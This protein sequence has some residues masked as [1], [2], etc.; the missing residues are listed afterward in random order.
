MQ[1]ATRM[2]AIQWV[3]ANPYEAVFN[4]QLPARTINRVAALAEA[5]KTVKANAAKERGYFDDARNAS[6]FAAARKKNEADTKY[7]WQ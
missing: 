7:C 2:K 4:E 3:E 5:I 6:Q 1:Q